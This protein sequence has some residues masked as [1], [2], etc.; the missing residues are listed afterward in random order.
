LAIKTRTDIQKQCIPAIIEGREVIGSAQTGSGKTAAFA[1]PILNALAKEPFGIQSLIITPTREL[2]FQ[3]T[4]QIRAFGSPIQ[5]RVCVITGGIDIVKQSSELDL[6]PH[7]LVATPGRL[8]D[9]L[10]N[11]TDCC[12]LTRIRYLVLD[13]A[14]QLLDPKFEG[15][16]RSIFNSI[17]S[18]NLQTLL[19]SATVTSRIL[20]LVEP[21]NENIVSLSNPFVYHSPVINRL[22]PNIIQKYMIVP[23]QIK[24]VYLVHLLKNDFIGKSIIIFTG[25]CIEAELI[26]NIL[27]R[28]GIPV[29]CLH[30][31]MPQKERTRSV[32][33]FRNAS[34]PILVATNVASRG[35]DIPKVQIVINY[36]IPSDPRDYIHRIGR[37]GRSGRD[38]LA[39]TL[40]GETESDLVPNLE[41]IIEGRFEKHCIDESRIVRSIKKVIKTKRMASIELAEKFDKRFGM[42]RKYST[43]RPD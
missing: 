20:S 2:A 8:I 7:I 35:L 3:I 1:L 22:N 23:L 29:A 11:S 24:I 14:D 4:E 36:T 17:R 16:I 43:S 19:F 25:K 9:I 15:S 30:S 10:T 6:R 28:F 26:G 32:F 27:N 13:E 39:L 31:K 34:I 41:K 21:N 18:S 40:V 12:D 37:T 5:V 42:S 38:G 33:R